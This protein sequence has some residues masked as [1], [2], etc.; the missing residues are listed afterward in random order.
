LTATDRSFAKMEFASG[1][2]EFACFE[3]VEDFVFWGDR[4]RIKL[5]ID[6]YEASPCLWN[7][8]SPDYKNVLKKKKA[9]VFLR[10][11]V[12]PISLLK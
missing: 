2:T 11:P 8:R 6:L 7:P 10:L 3:R 1:E 12:L 5:L 9:K 4:E